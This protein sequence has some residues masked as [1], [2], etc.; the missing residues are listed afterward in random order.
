MPDGIYLNANNLNGQEM[1]EKMMEA[2]RDNE[3]YYQYFKW[4]E[5]YSYYAASESAD[6]DPL[7]TLCSFLNSASKNNQKRVYARFTT[8]WNDAK[9]RNVVDDI[10]VYYNK[11]NDETIYKSFHNDA[12][13]KNTSLKPAV[14][15]ESVVN[16]IAN[17]ANELFQHYFN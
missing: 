2:I 16:T 3:H 4:R 10:I 8:W 1:A 15:D 7:C 5:H 11:S 9:D 12:S 14:L 13:H 6:T 17:I